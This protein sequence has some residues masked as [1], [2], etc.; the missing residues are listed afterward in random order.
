MRQALKPE[1]QKGKEPEWEKID[2][3][4]F[5]REVKAIREKSGTRAK[6]HQSQNTTTRTQKLRE[7]T[8][9]KN[10]SVCYPVFAHLPIMSKEDKINVFI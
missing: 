4:L 10:L 3:L 9:E 5:R 8:L 1:K 6:H 7:K 2:W